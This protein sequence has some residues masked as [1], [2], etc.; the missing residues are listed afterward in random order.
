MAAKSELSLAEELLDLVDPTPRTFDPEHADL[1]EA[2]VARLTDYKEDESEREERA[3]PL[4]LRAG[5]ALQ[6]LAEDPRYSGRAVTRRSLEEEEDEE[7]EGGEWV[8]VLV[9]ASSDIEVY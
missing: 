5:A 7:E 6:E 9:A 3:A 8:A 4:R 1:D 2:T